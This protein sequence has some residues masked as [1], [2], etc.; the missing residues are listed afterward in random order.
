MV[1]PGQQLAFWGES[2]HY[3][4]LPMTRFQQTIPINKVNLFGKYLNKINDRYKKDRL[5]PRSGIPIGL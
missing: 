5:L 2:L 3:L 4:Q 1:F